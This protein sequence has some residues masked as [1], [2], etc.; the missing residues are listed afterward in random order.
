MGRIYGL[1]GSERMLASLF[2]EQYGHEESGAKLHAFTQNL[3]QV[4]LP[5]DLAKQTRKRDYP[6]FPGFECG[7]PSKYSYFV[8]GTCYGGHQPFPDDPLDPGFVS[9][10]DG[11]GLNFGSHLRLKRAL[12]VLLDLPA[13]HQKESRDGL[14]AATKHLAT[15]EELIWAGIWTAPFTVSRPLSDEKKSYDWNIQFPDLR[16][17]LECKF[18]PANW[19][20]VVDGRDFELMKGSLARKASAQLPNP[21]PA[22]SINVVAVTGISPI[23]DNF[24][25]LCQNELREYPNVGVIMYGDIVGQTS[26]FSLSRALASQVRKRIKSWAADEFGGFSMITSHRPESARRKSARDAKAATMT[27]ESLSQE[28]V[29]MKMEYLPP[30]R[31][32]ALPPLEYPYRFELE[33][34]LETGEP[35]FRWVP[36][37]L[38]VETE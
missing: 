13:E 33:R 11:V 38:L 1:N 28:I 9:A 36:P 17:N 10:V 2:S 14:A 6:G 18:T 29:E 3:R 35:I 12:E 4:K 7:L 26:V 34:R 25:R 32:H 19:A 37:F 22:D 23:D 16:L 8:P 24:R 21:V 27:E 31:I 5:F 20:K 30:R 15:V